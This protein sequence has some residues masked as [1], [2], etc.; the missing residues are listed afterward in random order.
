MV[1]K[2]IKNIITKNLASKTEKILLAVSGGADSVVLLVLFLKAGFNIAIAHCNFKL[3]DEDSDK[4]EKFVRNLAAKYKIPLFIKTC[5][6]KEYSDS[7]NISIEMAARE[8]RYNWFEQITVENKFDKIATAHHS[9]DSVETILLN[10]SR[11][12]GIRGL[13]G[14]PEK[15][16]KIIRPLLFA[17]KSEILEYCD[18]NKIEFRTD[19]TNFE[20]N[21][22]RNK[23]RHLIIPEFE[24]LN[25]AFSRNVLQTAENL[26]FYQEFFNIQLKKFIQNCINSN[27][28]IV[29]IKIAKLKKYHP[30]ELFLYE[31]LKDFGFNSYQIINIT[32]LLD[33]Q[34]GKMIFSDKFRL[35]KER[36]TL[37]ISP[38]DKEKNIKYFITNESK[39]IKINEGKIDELTLNCKISNLKELNLIKDTN[40]GFFDFNKLKFPLKI[41]KWKNGDSFKPFGMKMKNKRLS[42]FFKD[43]KFTQIQ[44][45]NTW[46]LESDNKIVW[47]IGH[48]TDERFKITNKTTD[49]FKIKKEI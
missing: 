19:K 46:I 16:G 32:E 33:N 6:V 10:L 39:T 1:D 27:N 17:S 5:E 25:S 41:R 47:I 45:E 3:R 31:F 38:K 21:F 43:N 28:G 30:I 24:K 8:L 13:V 29:T 20:T 14:I 11:K 48:R 34:S 42:D 23:I 12:T 2:F 35:V 7:H 15:N 4:D 22:Q 36:D 26:K 49:I 37:I 9:D 44:K 18:K 40:Y